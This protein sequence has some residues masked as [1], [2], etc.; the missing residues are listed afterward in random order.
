MRPCLRTHPIM[1]LPTAA[2]RMAG[3]WRAS[4]LLAFMGVAGRPAIEANFRHAM[5]LSRGDST[6]F[7]TSPLSSGLLAAAAI[8]IALIMLPA[9]RPKR[10]EALKE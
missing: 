3:Q 2:G 6:V 1:T 7:V 10:E 9:I 4:A 5:V 8:A